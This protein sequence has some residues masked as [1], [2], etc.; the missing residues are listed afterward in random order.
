M[1]SSLGFYISNELN[2]ILSIVYA[3]TSI[4]PRYTS[5]KADGLSQLLSESR[6]SEALQLYTQAEEKATCAVETASACK[7][8]ALASMRLLRLVGSNDC[9]ISKHHALQV[10][11]DRLHYYLHM[12]ICCV[13]S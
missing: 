3:H 11:I 5:S 13:A 1:I 8:A 10:C 9:R 12:C 4:H 2:A 7:N 6:A